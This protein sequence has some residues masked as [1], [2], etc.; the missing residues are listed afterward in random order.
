MAQTVTCYQF[1]TQYTGREACLNLVYYTQVE[2]V[3]E[4][5]RRSESIPQI[6]YIVLFGSSITPA[7]GQESD[8]DILVIADTYDE[9]YSIIQRLRKGIKKPID[10]IPETLEHFKEAMTQGNS[11]Y[12]EISEKGIMIYERTS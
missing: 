3:R 9:E 12:R 7:C 1:S 10:I 11:L 2:A 6:Q 8:I 4:L 5:I